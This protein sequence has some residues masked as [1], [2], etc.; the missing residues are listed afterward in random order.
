MRMRSIHVDEFLIR[1]TVN[2]EPWQSE[3]VLLQVSQYSRPHC[4]SWR[5]H[6]TISAVS[7]DELKKE[8][9]EFDLEA[10]TFLDLSDRGDQ[11][12][13]ISVVIGPSFRKPRI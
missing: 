8:A 3:A 1:R 11:T 6:S 13:A 12:E 4:T 5:L 2:N 10:I 9:G 7:E